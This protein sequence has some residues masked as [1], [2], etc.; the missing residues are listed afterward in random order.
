MNYEK[1]LLSPGGPAVSPIVTGVMKWGLWGRQMGT[2]QMLHLIEAS[3]EAG[4]TTFDHAD[5]YGH[6]TTEA[7]F[8]AALKNRPELRSRIQ[9]V[10]KCGICLPGP[11]RQYG[12]KHYDTSAAHIRRSTE[13]SLRN[14]HTDYIDLLLIHR[15][16]PLMHPQEVAETFEAL[17]SEGKV[18]HFG[19]SNF[20]PAQLET[21]AAFTP[22]VTNQ[23][24]ANAMHL[25]PFSDGTFDQ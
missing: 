14:L 7:E 8:G 13:Q 10:T 23:V 6:Y 17:R 20:S 18:L 19:V 25:A 15:P 11:H 5:I 9:L 16:D 4:A 22:V 1:V 12:L 21:L 24:Q 3:V 2:T